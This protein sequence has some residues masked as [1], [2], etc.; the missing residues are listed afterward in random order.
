MPPDLI[1]VTGSS[2]ELGGRVAARLADAGAAQR[3]VVRDAG[4]A[5]SL[6]GSE[7]AVAAF[8]DAEA[9]RTALLGVRT[10]LLVP[11]HEGPGRLDVHATAIA[12]AVTAGVERIVYFSFVGAA[13]D[14]TFTYGRDHYATEQLIRDSGVAYTILRN[15][16]YLD[17]V[18][19]FT[20]AEGVLAGP[21][22]DGR[23]AWV[24]R[25]DSADVAAAVLTGEGHAGQT[26]DVTGGR[27]LTL[28]ETA[29]E[30]AE[31][32]GRPVRYH[33]ETVAE[34]Y[35]SRAHY[36]APDWQVEGWVTTYEAIANG[37][38]DTVTDTVRRIAGHEPQTLAEL[39]RR[40]PE[41]YRHLVTG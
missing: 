2:G 31:A 9:M 11:I 40:H 34:A 36:G 38:L 1:A 16:L 7:V 26:Y 25:D 6:P 10:L 22:A 41:N 14:C 3:L 33:P 30:L 12:A 39:L 17:F 29:R 27:A 37:E 13:P 4:R 32:I 23:V 19:F 21:A 28:A 20:S 15:S 8:E 24:A 35:A 5:P 18:P